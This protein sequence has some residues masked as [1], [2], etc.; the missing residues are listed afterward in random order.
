MDLD[1]SLLL[2]LVENGGL[3]EMVFEL[4]DAVREDKEVER[5]I[6]MDPMLLQ[7]DVDMLWPVSS[8]SVLSVIVVAL[9]GKSLL[10]VILS[11]RLTLLL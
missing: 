7:E 2:K 3:F 9:L 6:E 5:A 8:F 4:V 11:S 10:I 1:E